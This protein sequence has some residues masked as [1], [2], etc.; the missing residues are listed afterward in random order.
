MDL[1]KWVERNMTVLV[2]SGNEWMCECPKCHREKL[3]INVERKAWQCWVCRFSG[4]Q[5]VVLIQTVLGCGLRTAMDEVGGLVS[6]RSETIDPLEA[7]K[8]VRGS[9]PAAPDPPGASVGLEGIA[10]RYAHLR[11]ISAEHAR[12]FGLGS[13][14]G[15]GS[16]SK[17]D[18]LLRGRLLI[19]VW[20]ER[21]VMIYWTARATFLQTPKT[22]NCPRSE[23]HS[24]WGLPHVEGVADKSEVVIGLHLVSPGDEIIVVEGPMDAAVCGPGF[25]SVMGS[26]VSRSQAAAIARR[27]PSRATILFDPD[28]AGH[29]GAAAAVR[30]LSSYLSTTQAQCPEGLDPA[31]LGRERSLALCDNSSSIVAYIPPLEKT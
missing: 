31:M 13:V 1:G 10:A 23:V 28:E 15:D 3:A 20:D 14:R 8:A 9:F 2:R 4:W 24:E 7:E 25:V 5:P 18:R 22:L 21:R 19:P 6:D 11:G 30:L 17:A 16:G 26:K 12:L 29:A 27:R